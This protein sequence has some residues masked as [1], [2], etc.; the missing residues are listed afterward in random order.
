MSV[1]YKFPVCPK[2]MID[3]NN[4]FMLHYMCQEI[5]DGLVD[6]SNGY[7]EVYP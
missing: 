2:L 7:F 4:R 5:C 6:C 3:K 1:M